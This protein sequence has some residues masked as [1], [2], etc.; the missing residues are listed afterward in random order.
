MPKFRP[1]DEDL[2]TYGTNG[3]SAPAAEPKPTV[4]E[5]NAQN[6]DILIAKADL[7][8]GCKEGDTY[9]F[10]VVKDFGDEA[11][12]ELVEGNEP[13][14]ETTEEPM[15]VADRELTAMSEESD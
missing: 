11:S 6:A 2:E 9:T 7:P 5:E 3:T 15:D 12:L 4:D 14:S 8:K 10:R 13:E 1:S